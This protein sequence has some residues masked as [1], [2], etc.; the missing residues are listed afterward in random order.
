MLGEESKNSQIYNKYINSR[1]YKMA[2]KELYGEISHPK[3]LKIDRVEGNEYVYHTINYTHSP[4]DIKIG[5]EV[6]KTQEIGTYVKGGKIIKH[7]FVNAIYEGRMS[8]E[9]FNKS[10][11]PFSLSEKKSLGGYENMEKAV[12][13][14]SKNTTPIIDID[15]YT[16]DKFVLNAVQYKAHNKLE[17]ISIINKGTGGNYSEPEL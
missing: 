2:V 10:V 13:S 14:I 8:I 15:K 6:V 4:K 11:K 3:V 7:Y 12:S 5:E 16:N 9:D 1:E 17:D